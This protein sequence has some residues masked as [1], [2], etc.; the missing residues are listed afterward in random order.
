M[1]SVKAKVPLLKNSLQH[2]E[3]INSNKGSFVD[4]C[5][6]QSKSKILKEEVKDVKACVT[7][8]N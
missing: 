6:D 8:K 7:F 5:I 3:I 2:D 1:M 4:Y